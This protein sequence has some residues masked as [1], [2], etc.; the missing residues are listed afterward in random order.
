MWQ[1]KPMPNIVKA[2]GNGWDY[3]DEQIKAD[4]TIPKLRKVTS[5]NVM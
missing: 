2:L 1:P 3:I 4:W 5:W